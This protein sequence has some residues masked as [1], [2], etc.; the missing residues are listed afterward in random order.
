MGEVYLAD[1]TKLGREVALKVLAA[2]LAFDPER[3]DRFEREAR[4]VAALNHPEH[5]HDPLR[6]G[7][8]TASRS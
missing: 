6:R 1:D 2:A 8:G 5:R 7:S 3:R 4:A